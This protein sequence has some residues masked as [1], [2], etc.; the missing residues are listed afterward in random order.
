ML[1]AAIKS[2]A[3]AVYVGLKSF[4]ARASA[5]NFTIDELKEARQLAS[6]HN[7]KI[8]ITLNT[9]VKQKEMQALK[10]QILQL[11]EASPDAVIVQDIGVAMLVHALI[12]D[13]PL[14]ASTQ[15]AIHSASGARFLKNLGFERVILARECTLDTI[16]TIVNTGIDVEVFVH[17]ALCVAMSGQCL[18]SSFNGGRSGNRGRCAQVCRQSFIFNGNKAMHISARDIMLYNVLPQLL[19]IGVKSFKIEG[20]LK[21]P[22]YVASVCKQYRKGIDNYYNG[23]FDKLSA[24][25]YFWLMQSFN[26]GDFSQGYAGGSEDAKIINKSRSNNHGILIGNVE[27]ISKN[28]VYIKL[29]QAIHNNDMLRITDG[30][31]TNDFELIY[32]GKNMLAGEI[33]STYLRNSSK[34]SKGMQVYRLISEQQA[35]QERSMTLPRIDIDVSIDLIPGK[36]V[37]VQISN[38]HE[39]YETYGDIVAEARKAPLSK[40]RIAE[41]FS[42]ISEHNFNINNISIHTDNAFIAISVLNSIRRKA[43]YEFEK[44]LINKN[45][46]HYNTV[47]AEKSFTNYTSTDKNI[48]ISSNIDLQ[49]YIDQNS[50]FV[51]NPLDIRHNSLDTNLA[52]LNSKAYVMLDTSIN[53][54]DAQYIINLA[55]QYKLAGVVL[56]NIG[57][58]GM[59]FNGLNIA[60]GE[61]IPILNRYALNLIMQYNPR[62]TLA[63]PELSL[64]EIADIDMNLHVIQYGRERLMIF[65]H[66]PA[67]TSLG[68]HNG[69]EHCNMCYTGNKNALLG[70]SFIDYRGKEYP[71]IPLFTDY[72]CIV[73]MYNDCPNSIPYSKLKKYKLAICFVNESLTEQISIL[74]A[75]NTKSPLPSGTLGHSI[76]EII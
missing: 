45:I 8:Y 62:F 20:R 42:S 68:L 58:L 16:E 38:A 60:I 56:D 3:N 31:Q 48:V 15:M 53:D 64:R 35:E 76:D 69:K 67:R 23:K 72:K 30:V 1:H 9:I 57:Q 51:Y 36:P 41:V 33:A 47:K 50:I 73:N 54:K 63:H 2:G 75:F 39:S 6:L 12:P 10:E 52:M 29:K 34:I 22:S 7:V 61:H 19:S 11:V 44:K 5:N 71:L 13:L 59:D 4:G 26:R 46:K 43:Y 27:S 70:K 28:L 37:F 49:K 17:G 21:S 24:N 55:K 74:K 66:C 25:D 65:N 18:I 40:E 32:S 14:H